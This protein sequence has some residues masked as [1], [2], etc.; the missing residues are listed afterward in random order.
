M[1]TSAAQIVSL[2]KTM[3]KEYKGDKVGQ[4]YMDD[5]L[6][7]INELEHPFKSSAKQYYLSGLFNEYDGTSLMGVP[8]R[9]KSTPRL[10]KPNEVI[11]VDCN[12]EEYLVN[13]PTAKRDGNV[14]T[15]EKW[16]EN[17]ERFKQEGRWEQIS[18]SLLS[19]G[20]KVC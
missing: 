6:K 15:E 20:Y 4:S 13:L 12:G 2:I 3:K 19:R 16:Q 5:V 18:E 10:S 17:K 8:I 7:K 9:F 1:K 11:C 14:W